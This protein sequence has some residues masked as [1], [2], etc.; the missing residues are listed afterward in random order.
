MKKA[1]SLVLIL[2]CAAL[3]FTACGK[4]EPATEETEV[5][6]ISCADGYDNAGFVGFEA[7]Q[8][9]TYTF[10]AQ[11]GEGIEWAVYLFDEEFSDGPRYISQAAEPLLTEDGSLTVEA[12]KFLYV[13]CSANAFTDLAADSD[14]K[15][16]V[17]F[18]E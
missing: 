9:G 2:L 3:L 15:L 12:G 16:L 11:G 10:T 18:A 5:M 4:A 17:T 8:T 7:E 14:A 6:L 1:L 13:Y